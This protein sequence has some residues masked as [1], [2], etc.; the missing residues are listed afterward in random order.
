M[1]RKCT[2]YDLTRLT[3]VDYSVVWKYQKCVVDHLHKSKSS[4]CVASD[5]MI[6][7]EHPSLYTLGKAGTTNNLKFKP[8]NF[9][10][11]VYR[12]SR[13]G[14]VTWH[15]PGQLVVYPIVDLSRHKKDLRWY[16]RTLEEAVI[17]TLHVYGI[18]GERSDINPGVWVGTRKICA[19][20]VS[21]S[22]WITMHGLALNVVN[23]LSPFSDIIP[24][25]I[26]PEVGGVCSM[27]SEQAF[28]VKP[29]QSSV[30]TIS[31]QHAQFFNDVKATFVHMFS[32][33]FAF[34]HVEE[35][36]EADLKILFSSATDE[37]RNEELEEIT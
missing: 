14:E 9:D 17:R 18:K 6:L 28:V 37:I 35:R 10:G 13:G 25:G 8:S 24:C 23:D 21:A 20:G 29:P 5:S 27:L 19:V 36:D 2:V 32:E 31:F 7:V 33:E 30:E 3:S 34:D 16:I 12:V 15:G 1:I 4:P 26:S 11:K 22:R